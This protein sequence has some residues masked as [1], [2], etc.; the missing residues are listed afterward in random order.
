[1][2]CVGSNELWLRPRVLLKSEDRD[3]SVLY[4]G[5]AAGCTLTLIAGRSK[6]GS[7][8]SLKL[9]STVAYL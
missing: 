8:G 4:V 7:Q 3:P 5:K 2:L 6:E 1:M 9:N